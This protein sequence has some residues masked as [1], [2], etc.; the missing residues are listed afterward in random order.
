MSALRAKADISIIPRDIR[1]VPEAETG[2]K[3]DLMQ[4]PLL[5]GSG[6]SANG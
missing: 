6:H 2:V 5:A 1:N 3:A 4:R